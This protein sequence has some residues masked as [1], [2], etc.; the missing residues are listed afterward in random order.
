MFKKNINKNNSVTSTSINSNDKVKLLNPDP[1]VRIIPLGGLEEVGRNCTIIEY[2]EPET[3]KR[4]IIIVDLGLQFPEEAMMGIDFVIPNTY[5]L[6]NKIKDIRG[7]IITHGHYDHIGA[8]PYLMDKLGNPPIFAGALARSIILKRQDDFPNAQKPK[9]KIMNSGEKIDLGVF[10]IEFIHVN[11]NIPD[12]FS[13]Y[14]KTPTGT[15]YHSGD[16][17][18][19]RNPAMEAP[20]DIGRMANI[21]NEGVDVL[22]SDSTSVI[23]KGQAIPEESVKQ[24]LEKIF[25]QYRDYRI[26]IGTISSNIGRMAQILEI[27]EKMGRFVAIEGYS[28]KSNVLIIKELGYLKLDA[29][30]LISSKK[31]TTLPSNKVTIMC[32]GAQGEDRAAL[33]RIAQKEHKFIEL[34]NKDVVLFSS[35]VIPGNER[36]VQTVH[37]LLARQAGKVINYRMMGIHSGGHARAEDA[38]TLISLI[39]PKYLIPIHGNYFMLKAH[40]ELG[41]DLGMKPEHTLALDNGNIFNLSKKEFWVSKKKVPTNYIMVDGLGVGDVGEIVLRDRQKMA[42]EGMFTII[43]LI[44]SQTGKVKEP[45]DIISRGFIYM[46]DRRDLVNEARDKIKEIVLHTASQEPFNASYVRDE[47]REE[48]GEFLYKKTHRRPLILPVVM[49]I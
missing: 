15:I 7:I 8:I 37:D 5:Y 6:Q 13:L 19:D 47:L 45:I 32:T 35:S 44:D 40:T 29:K 34:T 42:E 14:I 48:L 4:D 28:M 17:K 24:E 49:K 1:R 23:E 43:I 26:I 10:N 20:S 18:F 25:D 12:S 16:F 3:K 41:Q 27:S 31:A 39:K 11:H 38:K 22:M 36:T 33:M 21:G 46:N 30:T 2:Y 9:I